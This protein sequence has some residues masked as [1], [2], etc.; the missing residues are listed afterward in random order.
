MLVTDGGL[1]AATRQEGDSGH[2]LERGSGFALWRQIA[3]TLEE[4][5]AR[6]DHPPGSRL[7]TEGELAGRFGVNRHTVRRAIAELGALALVRVEQGRGTF[8]Q[9]NVIDYAVGRRTRFSENIARVG[10]APGGRLLRS[11]C[12]PAS[13]QVATAL[14]LRPGSP[15]VL[16]ERVGE[17]DGR[18]VNIGLHYF[19]GVRFPDMIAAYREAGSITRA[20]E[21]QGL[22]DYVRKVTRVT[23]RMP[24]QD[25]AQI[26]QQPATRPILQSEAVNVDTDGR[27]VEYG[28]CRFA[29]DRMQLVFEP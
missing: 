11:A 4:E 20:L 5:I 12:A 25:E 7:S 2:G 22:S 18:P 28:I 23:A 9:E 13:E 19:C 16:I 3:R 8:V 29:G 27:P 17:V 14:G 10:G 6:G 21:R 26:L 1:P 15:V 24:S